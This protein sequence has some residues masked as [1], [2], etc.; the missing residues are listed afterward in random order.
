MRASTADRS[1]QELRQR[2]T[3]GL[4]PGSEC[5]VS[6]TLIADLGRSPPAALKISGLVQ[7]LLFG[8]KPPLAS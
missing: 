8:S 5:E 4:R 3:E 1:A 6:G 7:L 2:L